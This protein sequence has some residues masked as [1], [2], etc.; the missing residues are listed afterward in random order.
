MCTLFV[1]SDGE[2]E[3]IGACRSEHWDSNGNYLRAQEGVEYARAAEF[4]NK[5]GALL[6]LGVLCHDM[7]DDPNNVAVK[8]LLC[9]EA[10]LEFTMS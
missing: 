8:M 5:S 6:A 7:L 10:D 1:W 4:N 3:G 9:A 2:T